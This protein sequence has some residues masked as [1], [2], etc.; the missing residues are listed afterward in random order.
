MTRDETLVGKVG[1]VT[2]RI[3]PSLVGEV[4]LSVRGG[5]EA[6]FAYPY[7]PDETLPVGTQ[8]VVR[9]HQAPRTIYVSRAY[10]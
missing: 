2:G 9:E 1:R 3:G 5:S 7:D 4:M 8:V 10:L 6:F